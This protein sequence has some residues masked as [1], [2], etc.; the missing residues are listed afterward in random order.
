MAVTQQLARVPA[1]YLDACRQAADASEDGDHGWNP[2]AED[3]LDLDW[4]PFLL[5]RVAELATL[6]ETRVQALRQA[7]GGSSVIDLNFLDV[8]P[9]A[10]A[11]FGATP[12]ALTA[13]AV[14]HIAGV[15]DQIDFPAALAS[16]PVDETEAAL[17]I[18]HGAQEIVGGARRYLEQHFKALRDFYRGA[19]QQRL[20]VVLWWD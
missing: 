16:L 2:P 8:P 11:S 7:T 5:R 12:T 10:I 6:G 17:L 15:L 4:A 9:H 13:P 1:A 14:V 19:A 3:V 18:G 20:L